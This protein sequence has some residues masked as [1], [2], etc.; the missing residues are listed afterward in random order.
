[1]KL[2]CKQLLSSFFRNRFTNLSDYF[3][4]E[5]NRAFVMVDADR[6]TLA[7]FAG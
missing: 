4:R 5:D 3:F 7:K 1:M 6:V 2:A